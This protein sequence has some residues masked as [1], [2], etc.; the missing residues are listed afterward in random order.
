MTTNAKTLGYQGEW[1]TPEWPPLTM[2]EARNILGL[3]HQTGEAQSLLF[4][5]PRPFSAACLVATSQGEFFVKRHHRSVR[6]RE[7]LLE[8]H[9]LL[10]YLHSRGGKVPQVLA[11]NNGETAISQGEWTYEVHTLASGFDLYCEEQS[12]TPFKSRHH[13][14]AA[15]RALGELHY[16]AEGYQAPPRQA[17]SLVTS[18][19]IFAEQDPWPA[20]ERYVGS[21]SE[22]SN[23]LESRNWRE[24]VE[25]VLLPFHAALKPWL[26]YLSPLWTHNDFHGSNLLWSNDSSDA[27]VTCIIDFGLA[28][29]TNAAHDIA[30]AIERCGVEWL[31]MNLEFDEIV[32]LD[33]IDALLEGYEDTRSL[34]SEEAHAVAALLPLVHAEFALSEASYFLD[35][36]NSEEKADLAW[37]GY[38]LEHAQWFN[39]NAGYKLLDHL[40]SW[41]SKP[42]NRQAERAVLISQENL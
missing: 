5:S 34:T 18:F 25:A 27:E 6:D 14:Y 16:A 38:F 7:G 42:R 8:E 28:D 22:L 13:A 40:N 37:R 3:F 10:A 35:Q 1:M 23:Y 11:D 2:E 15:G 29:R 4:Q 39:S 17:R 32:H 36:L 9:R 30:T 31:A 12:W 20:I 41:A 33:Q 19:T 24:Q 21:R 26:S